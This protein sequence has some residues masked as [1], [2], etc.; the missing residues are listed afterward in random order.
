MSLPSDH[1]EICTYPSETLDQ[2]A[3]QLGHPSEWQ[4]PIHDTWLSR[5]VSY[6]LKTGN[7]PADDLFAATGKILLGV[8]IVYSPRSLLAGTLRDFRDLFV[9]SGTHVL[10]RTIP[11]LPVSL[12]F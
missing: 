3:I 1:V 12:D 8:S 11:S 9:I 10:Q 5:D 6:K 2:A 7:L 4:R